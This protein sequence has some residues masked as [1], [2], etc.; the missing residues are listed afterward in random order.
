M[1][2]PMY[3]SDLDACHNANTLYGAVGYRLTLDHIIYE[4]GVKGLVGVWGVWS[5]KGCK[6]PGSL[7]GVWKVLTLI[8]TKI[9]MMKHVLTNYFS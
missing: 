4:D 8:G 1:S 7:R 5:A 3:L 9:Y 2:P 6:R